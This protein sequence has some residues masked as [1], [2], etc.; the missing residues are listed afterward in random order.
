MDMDRA[1]ETYS[2]ADLTTNTFIYIYVY[3]YIYTYIYIHTYIYINL[4]SFYSH[5]YTYIYVYIYTYI[6]KP[7]AE[8]IDPKERFS[9]PK[10]RSEEG[11]LMEF[12]FLLIIFLFFIE[13]SM[14]VYRA[15]TNR[16]PSRSK[17]G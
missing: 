13:L 3:I 8:K 2:E 15:K 5:V 7:R 1:A 16:P 9:D 12:N 6:N 17:G 14:M 11:T 10:E 4:F